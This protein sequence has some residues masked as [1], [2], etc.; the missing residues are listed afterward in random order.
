MFDRADRVW[1]NLEETKQ[2]HS[3]LFLE[4]KERIFINIYEEDQQEEII[5]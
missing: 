5:S 2:R 3:K 1:N 4:Q